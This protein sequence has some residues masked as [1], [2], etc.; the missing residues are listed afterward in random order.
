MTLNQ[1]LQRLSH[2]PTN[3][4]GKD[5][6]VTLEQDY[7]TQRDVPAPWGIMLRAGYQGLTGPDGTP[8]YEVEEFIPLADAE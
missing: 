7:A 8:Q 3:V 1:L 5:T 6:V 4:R 2:I